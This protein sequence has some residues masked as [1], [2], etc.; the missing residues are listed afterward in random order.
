VRGTTEV[1][2]PDVRG[3]V[4]SHHK[5]VGAANHGR[6]V[7]TLAR[8]DRAARRQAVCLDCYPYEASST[9]LDPDKAARTREVL[10]TWSA[11]VPAAAGQRL[12]TLADGWGVGLRAAAERLLPGGAIYFTMDPADV[13]RVLLHPLTMVGSDGLPHDSRP[14]PRLWGTFPRVLGHYSRLRGLLPLEAAVHKMTGLPAQR[15]GIADRGRIAPGLAAD[16]VLFDPAQV[17]DRA[18]YEQ[19]TAPPAGIRAV[20]VNGQLA[21]DRGEPLAR[22]A[23]VR[24]RP[25]GA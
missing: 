16:L 22:H 2:R 11:A 10:V 13:D 18:T 14:H 5:V 1:H 12:R 6:T 21:M 17:A 25:S 8:I 20:F 4:V 24:L 9:M 15:F 3:K 7:A 23:G 19:P